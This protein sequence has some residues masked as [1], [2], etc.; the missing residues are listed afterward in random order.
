M[1]E[2]WDTDIFKDKVDELKEYVGT[3][4]I[5]ALEVRR[6]LF[7]KFKA[8]E[9]FCR[10]KGHTHSEFSPLADYYSEIT[11]QI[12]SGKLT[13]EQLEDLLKND[14]YILETLIHGSKDI[15]L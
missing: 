5:S 1:Q 8:V 11:T 3:L 6:T 13:D 4:Q 7:W 12:D 14:I 15:K 9:R 2:K 10:E